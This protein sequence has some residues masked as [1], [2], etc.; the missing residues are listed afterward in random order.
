M[1][2]STTESD[3][4]PTAVIAHLSGRFRGKTKRLAGEVLR[5]GTAIDA[6]IPISTRDL[7]PGPTRVPPGKPHA[8]LVRVGETYELRAS[9]EADIW[10]NGA[11]TVQGT[12]DSGDVLEIGEGGPVLRFR[13][14]PAGSGAFKSVADVFSDCLHCVR[15]ARNPAER[16]GLV[17]AGPPVGLLTQTA[18]RVRAAVGLALLSPFIAVAALWFQSQRFEARVESE[19]ET[20]R[21]MSEVAA[22]GDARSLS[23]R[24]IETLRAAL[25]ENVDR[26][27]VLEERS[28]AR[29]RVIAMASKS[30]VFVQGAWGFETPDGQPLRFAAGPDGDPPTDVSGPRM[31]IDGD[32][33][34][35]EILFTGTGFVVSHDGL[36]LTNRHVAEPWEFEDVTAKVTARGLR[37][38]MRRLQGF[39]PGVA[40]PVG[41]HLVRTS[42]TEDAALLR[43]DPV[44]A[45]VVPLSLAEETPR[46]G[47]EIVV[48]GYPTGI[49]ALV[50]RAD[51]EAIQ[52]L[53]EQG[54]LDFWDV[55]LQLSRRGMIAPLATA[56]VVGQITSGAVVYDAETTHGGS[57]GP[58]LGLDG[59]VVAINTA[60]L[61]E[62]GGSNLGVPAGEAVRL[63][64]GDGNAEARDVLRE[65]PLGPRLFR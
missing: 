38:V 23:D 41:L 62:F 29:A 57:G 63:L 25:S 36:V 55:A 5:I 56:G 15:H 20:V 43:C 28:G 4:V 54:P 40:E 12:L 21:R 27:A 51:A 2:R 61:P 7:P 19:F 64:L 53:R 8:T 45:E 35:V 39:L 32:G 16:A 18:P 42:E 44:D 22:L 1:T 65:I 58:V 10:V 59:R 3:L 6:D 34:P 31:T 14:Y 47:D 48:L 49:T 9:E 50:A 13:V 24:R 52:A 37:P 26:I 33:P 30:V 11:R 17:L 60:I 46:A